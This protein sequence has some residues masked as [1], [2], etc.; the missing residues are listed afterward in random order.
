[1]RKKAKGVETNNDISC[2]IAKLEKFYEAFARASR[3]HGYLLEFLKSEAPPCNERGEKLSFEKLFRLYDGDIPL[4]FKWRY[5]F[6]LEDNEVLRKVLCSLKQNGYEMA[7]N[8]TAPDA[9]LGNVAVRIDDKWFAIG[10]CKSFWS[11][12]VWDSEG[13]PTIEPAA[14][15]ILKLWP[16]F[17]VLSNPKNKEIDLEVALSIP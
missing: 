2:W 3:K 13:E 15:W 6:F 8:F 9:I 5:E 16:P 14:I 4:D 1:M 7:F 10:E 12:P 17:Y 11:N